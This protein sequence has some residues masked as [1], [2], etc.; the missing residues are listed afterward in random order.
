VPAVLLVDQN[1]R[2][3]AARARVDDRRKLVQVPLRTAAVSGVLEALLSA[4]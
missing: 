2:D 1:R 4:G 3:L